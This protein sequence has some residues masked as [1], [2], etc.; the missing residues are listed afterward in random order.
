MFKAF[1]TRAQALA[2]LK[3]SGISVPLAAEVFGIE[4]ST[5]WRRLNEE[6]GKTAFN[7]DTQVAIWCLCRHKHMFLGRHGVKSRVRLTPLLKKLRARNLKK[8]G[9]GTATTPNPS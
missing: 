5:L 4:H 7:R 1:L 6:K 8:S 2:L 3:E 9:A